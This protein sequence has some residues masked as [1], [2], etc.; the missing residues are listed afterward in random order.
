MTPTSSTTLPAED[1]SLEHTLESGQVFG[2]RRVGPDTWE[3]VLHGSCYR[4]QQAGEAVKVT[5]LAGPLE[6]DALQRYLGLDYPLEA[7][8]STF[9]QDDLLQRSV[10][11]CFGLRLL[12][13][14]LFECLV[15][16]I[17]SAA[18]N[19]PRI[20]QNLQA[21]CALGGEPCG[22]SCTFP[23]PERL[24]ELGEE[25]LRSTGMGFRAR[26][27]WQAALAVASGELDLQAVEQAP[28]PESKHL[29]MQLPG[30]GEKIA[31]C[32]CLFAL[33]QHEA[34]PV[35]TWI[36]R[37]LI[38]YYSAPKRANYA[39]LSAFGRERF[40]PK[41]GYA[42]QYLYHYSRLKAAELFG[43]SAPGLSAKAP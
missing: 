17:V 14:P 11:R 15:S 36:K 37:L 1:F 2:W 22:A 5:T 28:Y 23:S 27:M 7:I 4:L 43:R 24:V 19:I 25:A 18:N 8:L 38:A 33:G 26:Y 12:R 13:Q 42:Q 21:A 34:F 29:L 30:V 6:R 3:G 20:K 40:G 31:D 32:V 9:P 16:F 35:D 41:A 10:E 39:A